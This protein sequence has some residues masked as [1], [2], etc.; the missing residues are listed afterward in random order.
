MR[1]RERKEPKVDVCV[2][3]F[4]LH[5]VSISSKQIIGILKEIKKLY[6]F[7]MKQALL[8]LCCLPLT[9]L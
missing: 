8:D 2:F 4:L 7:M 9:S 6:I 3:S 1:Y 5:W